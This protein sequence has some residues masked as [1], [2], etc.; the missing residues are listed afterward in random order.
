VRIVSLLPSAT[1]I[2]CGLGLGDQ[3]VGVS[4][5]CDFP[6]EVAGRP[7]LTEPK[8]D[9]AADAAGIDAAVRRLVRDGLS[10]YRIKL[11]VLAQ[12]Q[13]DLIVTQQQCEVC[14]VSYDEVAAA[15]RELFD[16][17]VTIVSLTP[18][19]LGDVLDDV[20]RVADAAH[21]PEAGAALLGRMRAR[22]DAIRARATR[23][24][25][26]PRVACLEWLDPLMAA[27]NWVPELVELGGGTYGM[28]E[29]G[30]PS[31]RLTWDELV[32]Y[33]PDVIVAMP[34]GFRLPQTQ[35]ELPR[36]TQRPE[37]CRLPA[38]RNR[39]VYAVDGNAYLNRPGPRIADSAELL[40]GLIQPGFFAA[41]IPA[42]SY[43]RIET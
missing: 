17:P 36:L 39:R 15:A 20:Q 31:T 24:H 34:C 9:P 28:V 22:L 16:R 7:V 14:A 41:K 11:D 42:G 21:C 10:V 32:A 30:S 23:V 8:I 6:A 13:P 1:E 27:G 3:L 25:S 4:H 12:L 26:R 18:A 33:A 29:A 5:E 19:R 43:V 38:V 37:W 2:V 40:A 35:R